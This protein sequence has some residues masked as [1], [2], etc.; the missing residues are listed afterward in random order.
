MPA[1]SSSAIDWIDYDRRRRIL[2]V[3]FR[4]TGTYAYFDVPPN[5]YRAFLASD[6]KGG[7]FNSRIRGR[8]RYREIARAG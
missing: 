3:A 6:S 8:Y 2:T 7:F 4:E 1:V 5:L